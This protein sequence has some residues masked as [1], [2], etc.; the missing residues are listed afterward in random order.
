[1]EILEPKNYV[2]LQATTT[3]TTI[4]TYL[5]DHPTDHLRPGSKAFPSRVDGR[6]ETPSTRAGNAFDPGRKR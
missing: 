6:E 3:T 5:C 4:P 1:M 2:T